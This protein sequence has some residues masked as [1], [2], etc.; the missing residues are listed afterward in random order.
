MGDAPSVARVEVNVL[1]PAERLKRA[2]IA[3]GAGIAAALI[4][5]P[6]PLVHFFV[7]PGA[8]I[9]GL[10]LSVNRLRQRETFRAASGRCPHC[11]S[12][13]RF[14][15]LGGFRLPKRLD[16]PACHHDLSLGDG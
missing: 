7:V 10:M 5:L 15:I 3:L 14:P 13:Q 12:D 6:I 2:A 11:G 4:A 16:C 1:E 8:L 9:A